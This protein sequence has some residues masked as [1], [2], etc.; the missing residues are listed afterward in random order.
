MMK[1]KYLVLLLLVNSIFFLSCDSELDQNPYDGT[2]FDEV[3]TDL[4]GFN[5]AIAGCYAGLGADSNETGYRGY[6]TQD[7]GLQITPDILSDNVIFNPQGRQSQRTLFELRY[8]PVDEVSGLYESAYVVIARANLILANIDN[9]PQSSER[10]NIEAQARAIRAL[11]HFDIARMYAKIPT[12]SSDANSSMGIIYS[13]SY[14]PESYPTRDSSIT[15]QDTY[16]KIIE[17]LVYAEQN[18]QDNGAGKLNPEAISAILSRV[19]LYQGDWENVIVQANKVKTPISTITEF[20]NIWTDSFEASVLFKVKIQEVNDVAIGVPYSQTGTTGVRS[21]FVVAYDFYQ[22]F[23]DTD[24]RKS[25]TI[26]TSAFRANNYNNISKYFG[27]ASGDKNVVD[28][29]YIRVAEVFL[30]KAEAAFE[31]G[32]EAMALAALDEVR[33]NRYEGFISGNE[34]GQALEDAIQLERRLELAFESDRFFT[35]K[36]RGESINRSTTYGEFSDGTGTPAVKTSLAS[37]DD[38]WQLP[39][40]KSAIDNNS[41]ITQNPGY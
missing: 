7:S 4:D 18:I 10:D 11:A 30:N 36:R 17:D 3:L 8:T 5:N 2:P 41:N 14:S 34:S 33:S 13:D 20:P 1:I 6:F 29:K 39:I 15:V 19:Y 38:R 25:S 16:A 24:I 12:Q 22:L 26:S 35:L 23:Q 9:I 37:G 21:E 28:G 40:P 32:D 27:R 31:N